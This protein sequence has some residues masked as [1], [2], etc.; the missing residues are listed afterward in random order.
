[1]HY[2]S[3]EVSFEAAGKVVPQSVFNFVVTLLSDKGEV[4]QFDDLQDL[5]TV[6]PT[7]KQ[8]SLVQSQQI[9]H[10]VAGIPTPLGTA[11]ACHLYN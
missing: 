9:K 5:A 1:M 8:K 3:Q 4:Q 7:I 11:T 10:H 2:Q 6:N